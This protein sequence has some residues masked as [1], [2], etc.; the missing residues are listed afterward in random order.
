MEDSKP[1]YICIDKACLVLHMAIANGSWNHTWEKTTLFVVD[2]YHYIDHQT[3]NY[4]CRKWC[5][6]A[7][8]DGL[9]PNLVVVEKDN[10]GNNYYKHA[11]NT[12]V[13]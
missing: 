3:T 7:P 5:N 4:M 8:L 12:Q 10:D 9:A 1:D 13:M 2:S 11:F 6:P